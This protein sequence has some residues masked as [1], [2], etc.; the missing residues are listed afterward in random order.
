MN[1]QT[2][3]PISQPSITQLEIDYVTDALKSGWVSS[4][5]EY[6]TKFE[7]KFA[8][9]CGTK[10]ALTTA[11]GTTGIHLALATYGIKPGDE[12]IVPDFTFI[13]TANAVNYTGAKP[14]FVDIEEDTLC[15]NPLE[16][17]KAITEKTKA[18]IAVHLYGHPANMTAI[19]Q[20]AQQYNL[21]VME[22]TAEAHGASIN[23]QK[24]GSLSYCGIFS[25]YGNKIVTSG[26]G[27]MITTNDEEFYQKAKHLRDHAMS[28]SKR[29]W[30]DELGYNYRMTNMQAALGLAQLERIDEFIEKRQ[31]IFNEYQKNLSDIPGL[32]L[33][34]TAK[35]ATNVY[36]L[37]CLEIEGYTEIERNNLMD[38]LKLK[39]IDTRPYFYPIS[40]MP[41]YKNEQIYTP[42]THKVYQRGINLPCYFDLTDREID[43]ICSSI[44]NYL[45]L[46]QFSAA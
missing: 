4:L 36:W 45:E 17:E 43:Y 25:F 2:F 15:I 22:D 16:I 31:E 39:G 44:G 30:H 21:I 27:G 5:G 35:W 26:E 46:N 11:N 12:V 10:Y 14:V 29:Y 7:E 8:A 18:I 23:G 28:S 33:N 6:I 42:I 41:M 24:V 9:Y 20:L 32:K 34:F 3:I 1:T 40:D 19:N 37:I 38:A 13:A